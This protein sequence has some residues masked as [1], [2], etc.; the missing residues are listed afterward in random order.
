MSNFCER[1][2]EEIVIN[3]TD[4]ES[5]CAG[6]LQSFYE[7]IIFHLDEMAPLKKI[8]LKEQRL[9]LKPWI[10]RDILNKCKQR[11]DLL[12]KMRKEID[13][14]KKAEL[15][16]NYKVLRNRINEEKRQGKNDHNKKQFEKNKNNSR[17]IWKGIHSLVNIKSPKSFSIKL[18]DGNHDL[19][20]DSTKIAIIFNDHY[21]TIGTKVQQKIPTQSGYNRSYLRKRRSDGKH[22]INPDGSSFFCVPL[23]YLKLLRLLMD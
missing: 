3:D 12:D 2:F 17:H 21:S 13:L 15:L 7:K 23:L 6:G 16:K 8:S 4:W 14:T 20:S 22:Y 1:E 9:M 5:V 19:I 11:D 18:L 10:T